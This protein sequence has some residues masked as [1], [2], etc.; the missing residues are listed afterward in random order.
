M[1]EKQEKLV[2]VINK[3][4]N[5]IMPT[6]KCGWVRHVL[7]SK[8]AKVV[9]LCPFIIQILYNCPSYCQPITLGVDTGYKHIG[10]SASTEK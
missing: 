1:K 5:P 4:G 7:K 8:Q 6:K 10:L 3:E 9:C 2:Y